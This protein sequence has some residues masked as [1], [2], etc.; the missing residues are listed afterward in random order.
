MALVEHV[1]QGPAPLTNDDD[2]L[3]K[4]VLAHLRAIALRQL[5]Q[6][7]PGHTLTATALVNEVYLKFA[8]CGMPFS[9]KAQFYHAAAQAMRRLLIDHARRRNAEKRKHK[10]APFEALQNVAD[11]AKDENLENVMALENAYAQLETDDPEAAGVVRLRFYAGM[12]GD[13][14]AEVLGISPRQADRAW[15]YAR[16]FLVTRMR[17][18]DKEQDD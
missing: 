4:K 13:Q 10:K 15:D 3:T 6:E 7:R 2:G 9:D 16:A 17:H 5:A 1:K 12:T 8:P 18:S 11:L 14:A